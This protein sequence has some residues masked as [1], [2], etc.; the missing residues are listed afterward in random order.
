MSRSDWLH[1]VAVRRCLIVALFVIPALAQENKTGNQAQT[2]EAQATKNQAGPSPGRFLLE[3]GKEKDNTD[4]GKPKCNQPQSHDEADLCEQRRMS[5][6]AEDAVSLNAIQTGLGAAGA[7]ILVIT[8]VLTIRGTK[9]AITA[10][11]AAE[12]SARF[13]EITARHVE[14]PYVLIGETELSIIDRALPFMSLIGGAGITFHH[15]FF[16]RGRTPAVVFEVCYC[17]DFV[18]FG[19]S[20]PVAIYK[21]PVNPVYGKGSVAQVMIVIGADGQSPKRPAVLKTEEIYEDRRY[22]PIPIIYGYVKYRDVAGRRYQ[23]GFGFSWIGS[24]T[25]ASIAASV[26]QAISPYGDEAYNYDRE[27]S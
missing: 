25:P 9:A 17:L 24:K 12:Q 16:N 1:H 8:L 26:G 6:A 22:G 4:W 14:R 20:S 13:S 5:K 18:R 15:V 10:A 7:L 11:R 19:D 21:P 2:T 3:W 27:L 23:A